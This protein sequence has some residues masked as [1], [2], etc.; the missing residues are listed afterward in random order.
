MPNRERSEVGASALATVLLVGPSSWR[1][2]GTASS[3]SSSR[4]TTGP[5]VMNSA[6]HPQKHASLWC[7]RG[8]QRPHKE[9]VRGSSCRMGE[10][11]ISRTLPGHSGHVGEVERNALADAHVI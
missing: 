3:P 11:F 8:A 1:Q 5:L 10:G 6:A 4:A 9:Q 2:A 7:V